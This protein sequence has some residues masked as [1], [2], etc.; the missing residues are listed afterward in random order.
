VVFDPRALRTLVD[1]MG[2]SQVM[3]GS[4]YPYPL[5]ERPVGKVVDDAD[6]LSESDRAALR[7][8]NASRFLG[9]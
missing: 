6:F 2:V 7:W 5:G 1:T 8:G 9:V 3:V 4:D